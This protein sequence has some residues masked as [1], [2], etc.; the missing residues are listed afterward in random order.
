VSALPKFTQ[1]D[2]AAALSRLLALPPEHPG[3]GAYAGDLLQTVN[4]QLDF[5]K[6]GLDG[7]GFATLAMGRLPPELARAA[8]SARGGDLQTWQQ[9]AAANATSAQFAALSM[10]LG[11]SLR[12][13]SGAQASRASS[14]VG[15]PDR[16]DYQALA[17][18][19]AASLQGITAQTFGRTSFASAGLDYG[20]FNHLRSYDRNFTG[21]DI[22]SAAND[23]KRLGFDPKNKR[24]MRNMASIRHYDHDAEGSVQALEDF[25]NLSDEEKQELKRLKGEQTKAKSPQEIEAAKKALDAFWEQRADETGLN[26]RI[27]DPGRHPRAREGLKDQKDAV[28]ELR[29]LSIPHEPNLS[30]DRRATNRATVGADTTL[31]DR[32]IQVI[33]QQESTGQDSA[34][35]LRGFANRPQTPSGNVDMPPRPGA[36]PSSN[37][38]ATTAPAP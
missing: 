9:L 31:Q 35:I 32:K 11:I 20:T 15:S 37:K 33:E 4:A 24:S 16:Q 36:S 14:R 5:R 29:E 21:Q 13:F 7:S 34:A 6:A 27:A 23:V 18:G 38:P 12:D 26:A 19:S 1:S 28:R 25:G 3:L 30:D 8:D 17:Y 22:L 2:V 10:R